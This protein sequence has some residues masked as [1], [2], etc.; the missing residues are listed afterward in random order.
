MRRAGRPAGWSEWFRTAGVA[1]IDVE[2]GMHFDD[3][4]LAL[5]AAAA[6]RGVALGRLA[7]ALDDLEAKR[8]KRPFES[9]LD[10]E[11]KYHLLVPES[12]AAEPAIAAFRG[13]IEQ[14]ASL[15]AARLRAI[16]GGKRS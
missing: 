6:G 8:L 4:H 10:L 14:E 16:P 2:P 11:L 12:R 13:W 7:Y 15:F 3:G 9:I 5:Q 1:G